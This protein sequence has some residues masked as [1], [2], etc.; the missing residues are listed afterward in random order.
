MEDIF[1]VEHIKELCKERGWSYYTLSKKSGIPHSSLYTMLKKSHIPSMNN[2]IKI[3][4][5]FD[6]TLSQFFAPLN[7]V[8][9]EQQE[10]LNLWSLLDD[11]P[12]ALLMTYLC[13]LAN[14]PVP[15][16]YM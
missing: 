6:I 3:C 14:K 8:T 9:N 11:K 1:V 7:G 10:L 13:G 16:K 2:L 5:G 4:N 12:R 15:E